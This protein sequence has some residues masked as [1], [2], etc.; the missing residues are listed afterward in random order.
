MLAETFLL[1]CIANTVILVSQLMRHL[2]GY[3]KTIKE[4]FRRACSPGGLQSSLDVFSK[5]LSM[6]HL[7]QNH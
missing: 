1:A 5:L 4:D 3:R 2:N 7:H 6:N